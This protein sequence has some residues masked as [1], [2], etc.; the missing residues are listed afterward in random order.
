MNGPKTVQFVHFNF[1]LFHLNPLHLHKH[2]E[3][4]TLSLLR[5]H[6]IPKRRNWKA[7]FFNLSIF[8]SKTLHFSS[9]IHSNPS[10]KFKSFHLLISKSKIP[11]KRAS[12][13]GQPFSSQLEPEHEE[14]HQFI[15]VE[16]KRNLSSKLRKERFMKKKGSFWRVEWSGFRLTLWG[17][18]YYPYTPLEGLCQASL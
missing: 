14:S 8:L 12:V 18:S 11:L 10:T 15:N 3:R 7:I 6:P 9:S 1:G 16:A 13:G 4:P 2:R 17:R 5:L